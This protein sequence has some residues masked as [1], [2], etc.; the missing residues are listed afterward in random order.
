MATR[1]ISHSDARIIRGR[2]A[3]PRWPVQLGTAVSR[4]PATVAPMNPNSISWPCHS[5]GGQSVTRVVPRAKLAAHQGT[6]T[7]AASPEARK[8]GRNPY[9]KRAKPHFEGAS[10]K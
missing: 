8:N 5:V 3:K 2:P 7:T 10:R 4:K 6:K 1:A 9:A